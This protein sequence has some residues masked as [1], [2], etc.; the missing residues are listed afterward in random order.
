MEQAQSTPT[1]TGQ[2]ELPRF[3]ELNF[4]RV[5]LNPLIKFGLDASDP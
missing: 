4:R 2:Q 1:E 5:Q 3:S